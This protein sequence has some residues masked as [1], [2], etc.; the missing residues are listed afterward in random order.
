MDF[1]RFLGRSMDFPLISK[2]FQGF[3]MISKDFRGLSAKGV[4]SEDVGSR[5]V[6]EALGGSFSPPWTLIQE[7]N[8]EQKD[9][10]E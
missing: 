1:Q 4:N 3:P 2:D 7:N 5:K 6:L 9:I 8:Q 10:F